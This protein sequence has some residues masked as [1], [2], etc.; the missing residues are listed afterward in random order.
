MLRR[1]TI[2]LRPTF[3]S[4][5]VMAALSLAAQNSGPPPWQD[6]AVFGLNKVEPHA[7]F[8]PFGEEDPSGRYLRENSGNYQSLNGEWKFSFSVSPLTEPEGY[9]LPA[10]DDADWDVI[11]VPSNW[12]LRGYGQPIYTNQLHPFPATPP[13]VPVDSNETGFYRLSFD[14]ELVKHKRF[15]LHFAGVQSAFYVFLNGQEVGYSEGSMTPA[16]FDITDLLKPKDN[17]L[18][19]KVMR[20][21]DASYLE[22]QDFWRLSGIYRD[23][24]LYSVPES[25]LWDFQLQTDLDEEYKDAKLHVNGLIKTVSENASTKPELF[26]SLNDVTGTALFREAVDLVKVRDGY[27]FSFSKDII[28]PLLWSDESP[29]L[30]NLGFQLEAA[31]STVY[32]GQRFGFREVEIKDAQVH[33]NGVPV[34]TKGVNRHEFDPLNG[35]VVSEE[36]MIRDI[37]LMKQHNINAV[38]TSHYPDQERWYDLCDEYGLMVMDE[39]NLESHYLWGHKNQ[40]PALYPQWKEAI[41][42]RGISMFQRDKNHPCVVMWS[43]G[44]EAGNGPNIQAMYDTIRA[45]DYSKR[46]IHYEGRSIRKPIEWHSKNIFDEIAHLYSGLLYTRSL[47]EYDINSGMYPSPKWAEKMARKDPDRPV[48][49]CEYAHAMGNSTGHFKAYWDLFEKYPNMQGGYIWDWVDQG[50]EQST[51]SGEIYFV[52]GGFFGEKQHDGDFCINGLVLPDRTPKPGLKEVK[53]VQQFVRFHP[54]DLRAGGIEIEN[55]YHFQ[56]FE[57]MEAAW[58]LLEDGRPVSQGILSLGPVFPGERMGLILPIGEVDFLAGS[59]YFVKVDIRLKQDRLWADRGHVVAWEQFEIENPLRSELGSNSDKAIKDGLS[60]EEKD[61]EILIFGKDFSLKFSRLT[62]QMTQW[63]SGGE[64]LIDQGP[65][66][67]VWR[68][69]TSNDMGTKFNSDPRFTWH[70]VQWKQKG[71]DQLEADRHKMKITRHSSGELSLKV[72][73]RLRA[74]KT[75][76]RVRTVYTIS[77]HGKVEVDQKVK[78]NK[79]LNWPKV[80]MVLQL[81]GS[82][83]SVNWFGRGPHEN[84]DDRATSAAFGLYQSSIDDLHVPYVKPMENGNRSSVEWL[85]ISKG[86]GHGIRVEGE[87]LNFSA[88]H[89]TVQNLEEASFEIDLKNSGHVWL[90]IDHRQNALGSESFMFNYLDEYVLKGRKFSYSYSLEAL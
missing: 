50:L 14:L 75:R 84:Y 79:K 57:G 5:L 88:H 6:P 56:T 40:S 7:I 45:M 27:D 32:Y 49:I 4:C 8:L 39:A 55:L 16:E 62:G 38:R 44:N 60:M 47:N 48:I 46:P 36:S 26:I 86:N 51:E 28:E 87:A 29:T 17:L 82:Y 21:S 52:Y 74:K 41:L 24:F 80:G 9:Y 35:R 89:Y 11:D 54:V 20:W 64:T 71:L 25:H 69:P 31:G 78:A 73:Y 43:M 3:I 13:T 1:F 65:V 63:I 90:N 58:T 83:E 66:T 70:W 72:R 30:Y 67:S 10:T 61:D 68:A 23:V 12:Q 53:K 76:I 34:Y 85:E 59:R 22:D 18:A 42:D 15:I 33:L 2:I 77:A 81:P 37:R 19:V